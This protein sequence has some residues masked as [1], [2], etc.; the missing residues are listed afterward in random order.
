V[1]LPLIEYLVVLAWLF[2]LGSVIGSLLNVCI[3]RLPREERFWPALKSLA[4]PPSHCPRCHRRIPWYDNVPIAG[5]LFLRGRCRSC[6]GRI[7]IR[8]PLV[9]AL[10]GILFVLVYCCEIPD[11]WI[12]PEAGSLF[13]VYGPAGNP[14]S[15]WMYPLALLHWRYAL[16][17]VLIVA[18][19]MATFIDF[20]L[21]IIP[22][23]VTLPAMAVGLLG[24]FILG[25]VY[26]VPLWYQTPAM[27]A[28]LPLEIRRFL[29]S[30]P[31][32]PDIPGWFVAWTTSIGVPAWMTTH[33]L[34]HGLALSLA[35]IVV[36]GGIV[37]GVRIAGQWGLKRE[38]MGFGDVVL[39]AMIGAFLGWQGAITVF[40]LA[41]LCALLAVAIALAFRFDR[42]IPYGPY[43]SLATLIL[44]LGW[45]WIWPS[46][47]AILTLGPFLPLAG[48]VLFLALCGML[49]VVRVL[50]TLLGIQYQDPAPEPDEEWTAGD[51][52]AHFA[53]ERIEDS[54]GQWP[55][56]TWPGSL[57]SRGLIQH[58]NWRPPTPATRNPSRPRGP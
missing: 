38:A 42:E 27:A 15:A 32:R 21:K 17:M 25:Q 30:F 11:W 24:N 9:E 5:W 23:T 55:R 50:Q 44:L 39:L 31:Q 57:S 13:H 45:R 1:N 20:D 46:V 34:L 3:H 16:H 4:Y 41:P 51:Q 6:R 58:H 33:P 53:N 14:A 18:L 2:A 54:T 8:Y 35:G 29:D 52:L 28:G 22:D 47:E 48:A 26:V 36:G 7:S 10:T 37:W 19:I 56:P 40:F 43:L 12:G 49:Y